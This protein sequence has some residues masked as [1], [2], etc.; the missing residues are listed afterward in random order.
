MTISINQRFT[1]LDVFRGMTICLMIIVNTPGGD[2]TFSPLQHASWDGFTPTDL[3]FPSFMFAVGNAMSFVMSKWTDMSTSQVVTKI[4]KRTLT[5]FLLGYLMYWF[6]FVKYDDAHNLILKPISETRIFGVLQRIALAYGATAFMMYFLKP[7]LTTII[8]MLILI[9]YWPVMVYFGDSADPLSM[10][11]NAVLRLDTWLI[12]T[13]HL[14][15]GEGFPFDPEGLLSTLP[16]I[17]NVVAGYLVGSYLQKNG[18]SYEGLAKLLMIGVLCFIIS[19]WWNLG[20]PINKKLWSSS[21]V[22]RTVGLDCMIL[23]CIIYLIDFLGKTKS[24]YFFQVFGRNPLP[25]YLLSEIG[26]IILFIIPVGQL[27]L[28]QW[29]YQNIFIYAGNY[30]ASLLFAISWML[31]CWVAGYILDKKKI[32]IKV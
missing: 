25:I 3:V 32:Y 1:A 12:G 15:M 4:L 26:V 17:G 14:Y 5:I 27:S 7:R 23:A 28:F 13:K 29:V 8:T 30:F 18:K 19:Y 9:L 6:P 16:S 31:F 21:F 20:F 10:Q 22:M 11:G 24:V 2:P